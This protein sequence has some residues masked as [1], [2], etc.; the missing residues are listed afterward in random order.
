MTLSNPA[1]SASLHSLAVL[2]VPLLIPATAILLL[3]L[4]VVAIS[5]LR[6]RRRIAQRE[7]R[8]RVETALTNQRVTRE[9]NEALAEEI[10]GR[11]N[12][13]QEL[14]RVA[15]HDSLTGL[16]N[17][18]YLIQSLER[19]LQP[20]NTRDRTE[21]RVL[22]LDLDSFKEF[23]DM[24][25][26]RVGDLL[27]IEV[28]KRLRRFVRD[29]DTLV[30]VGG[31]EFAVVLTNLQTTDQAMRLAERL[32]LCIE[33]PFDLAGVLLPVTA[34]MGLCEID[35]HYTDAEQVLHDADTAMCCAKRAGGN[36][37]LR[38]NSSMQQ[39][40]LADVQRKLQLKAGIDQGEFELFFQ[41]L[42]DLDTRSVYGM[43]ALIRWNHPS[44]GLLAP[45]AFI[46]LAEDT[47]QIVP[48][49]TWV[50]QESCRRL[51][52]FQE[53]TGNPLLMSLN[54]SSKQLDTP[55]FLDLLKAALADSGVDPT[56][57]Q[58]EITESIFLK[59]AERIGQLFADIREL[60][61]QIAFDDFGTGYSSLC[62]LERY[63]IDTLKL[64]Q[65]FVQHM[66]EG[67][68][69]TEIVKMVINLADAIGMKV[70]AE[71]VEE[72]QQA[73][74]LVSFG[75]SLAQGYLFSKPV[76]FAR[77]LE[78][79]AADTRRQRLAAHVAPHAIILPFRHEAQAHTSQSLNA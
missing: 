22:Y 11:H 28:G 12:I 79:I 1:A 38:Y 60:G 34:S 48:M 51:Q 17:R 37:L 25:G 59:D 63:P 73:L 19:L 47:G 71:G 16:H 76:P 23:N 65:S 53:I 68:V 40:A 21:A 74:D 7:D 29:T 39:D 13:E 36:Q 61:V 18:T 72:E 45:G 32:L 66:T 41:P 77:M 52:Q 33:Q 31:N 3:L 4:G 44:R 10:R 43:E 46:Q 57:I 62:Y 67:S 30:R 2:S 5:F 55:D 24:L 9:Q 64:D 42:I 35:Q 20:V 8:Q 6:Y 58:L 26:R 14:R 27:L 49:G 56:C 70:S 69:N 78:L 50:M 54:V 75:C 15:F